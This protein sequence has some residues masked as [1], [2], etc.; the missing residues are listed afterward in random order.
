MA[1]GTGGVGKRET[2]R[3]AT[4]VHLE[5]LSGVRIAGVFGDAFEAAG[6]RK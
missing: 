4:R 3:G 6:S 5:G 1:A 2:A